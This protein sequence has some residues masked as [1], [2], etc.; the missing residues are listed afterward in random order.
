MKKLLSTLLLALVALAGQGQIH[1]RLEGTVGDSTLN[2]R[3][4]LNQGMSA[5]KLVNAA[6]DT[7]E[8]V[9]GKIIPKEGTLEEPGT[10]DLKS[11]TETDEKPDIQS[12]LFIIE[13]G[14]MHI[15]FNQK[16]EEY[17]APDTPLN[18]A[19]THFVN[20]F[21]PLLHGDSV[22]QQ[23][24]DSLMRSELGHHDDD[25][26]GM[27]ALAMVFAHV[28]PSIV[29]SWLGLMSPR[30]KA[31]EAW[32]GMK[33]GLSA[34]GVNIEIKEE[35]FSPAVG[36]KFKDFAVEYDGKTIRLSDYV[37]R[38]KYVLVDFW[39]SW[40]G[41]CRMEIP[42]IIGAYNKNKEMGLEVVGIAAWD[43]PEDTLKAIEVEKMPY[44]QIINSQKIATDLY[45]IKGI[46][47]TILFAPDGT[48]LARGLRGEELEKK[49]A[50]I[51]GE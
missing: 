43:K 7:L 30:V 45:G 28:K 37:G 1:Y 51:F 10:F 5:M 27:Q 42:N 8:V 44:P 25:V 23:R 35:Y 6:I 47:E 24:L 2:T 32:Y 20:D 34:M 11:I 38:G 9:N 15:H 36:E 19:F 16:A 29:A 46:P 33:M 49:L 40:C 14:T 21:Y 31:G 22:R 3:L 13:E 50:E 4:L 41:P 39:A 26:L 18:R 12:P 48:I 17:K